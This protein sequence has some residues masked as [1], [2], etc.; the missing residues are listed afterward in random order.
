MSQY[1]SGYLD[2]ETVFGCIK[3][4]VK[5]Q[6]LLGYLN[7]CLLEQNKLKTLS[8]DDKMKFISFLYE[9]TKENHPEEIS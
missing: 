1:C 4:N 5:T 6:Q 3:N 9:K 8:S 2:Q 7:E